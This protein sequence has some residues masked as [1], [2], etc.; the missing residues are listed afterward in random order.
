MKMKFEFPEKYDY[1]EIMEDYFVEYE[2]ENYA[3]GLE[4]VP[5]DDQDVDF[6]KSI[7]SATKQIAKDM[8]FTKIE[9]GAFLT[10][11]E[12]AYYIITY[13]EDDDRSIVFIALIVDEKNKM[14]YEID[15]YCY[16]GNKQNGIN[17]LNSLR[18]T[19]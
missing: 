7:V 12:K 2:S 8:T 11:F 4:K 17:I 1:V 10:N 14:T 3:I 13:E 18:F 6:K 16:D 15:L 5:Y 19:H 9:N